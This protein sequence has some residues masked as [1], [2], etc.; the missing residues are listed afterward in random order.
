MRRRG[1]S[2]AARVS[3]SDYHGPYDRISGIAPKRY[4]AEHV[5][6]TCVFYNT[7]KGG[8]PS[9][10]DCKAAVEDMQK[11]YAGVFRD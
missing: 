4:T 5:T 3:Y 11:L 8:V 2:R 9:P 10:E 1:F 6:V 7:V